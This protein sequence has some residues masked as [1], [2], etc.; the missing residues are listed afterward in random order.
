[1]H[2]SCLFLHSCLQVV[3]SAGIG[4]AKMVM[5]AAGMGVGMVTMG[6]GM[7]T[8][9]GTA[10][11]TGPLEPPPGLAGGGLSGGIG[12]IGGNG[13]DDDDDDDKHPNKKHK[14]TSAEVRIGTF[15]L[16]PWGP[17]PPSDWRPR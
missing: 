13:D 2:M 16:G 4:E 1:M 3:Q 10:V 7:E 11:A 17:I 6:V 12:G 14:G 9:G 8:G 5:A 15:H